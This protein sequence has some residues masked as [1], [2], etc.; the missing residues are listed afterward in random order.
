M[1]S[2]GGG[3]HP[4]LTTVG[5]SALA[6]IVALVLVWAFFWP[7]GS[8]Q[9]VPRPIGL[10]ASA[11]RAT[12]VRL[13]W[14]SPTVNPD[15]YQI[16]INGRLVGTVGGWRTSYTARGLQPDTFYR[17]QVFAVSGGR[18]SRRPAYSSVSTTVPPVFAATLSGTWRGHLDVTTVSTKPG[19]PAEIFTKG[20][21]WKISWRF[22]PRCHRVSCPK[23]TLR[24]ELL[25]HPGQAV[26]LTPTLTRSDGVYSA[27]VGTRA[28][29]CAAGPRTFSRPGRLTI[30][31]TVTKA[32]MV[33]VAK[34][35]AKGRTWTA[36]ALTGW[37]TLSNPLDKLHKR[38]VCP[39]STIVTSISASRVGFRIPTSA[40]LREYQIK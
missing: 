24:G 28:D 22:I 3:N 23:V 9:P 39:A 7:H 5:S 13:T 34:A 8:S 21:I 37:M 1:V 19:N 32:D 14:R 38:Y 31:F 30:K 10:V 12:S 17:F 11:P 40:P 29:V 35:G 36:L 18:R 2:R 25:G 20:T 15:K 26:R 27:V 33:T 16:L 4:K 6:V